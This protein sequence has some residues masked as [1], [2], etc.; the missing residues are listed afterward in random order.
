MAPFSHFLTAAQVED[1][2]AFLL[3]QAEQPLSPATAAPAHAQ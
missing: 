1:V 3:W 2:R